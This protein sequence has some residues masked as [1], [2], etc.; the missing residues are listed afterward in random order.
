[1]NKMVFINKGLYGMLF[2]VRLVPNVDI[3]NTVQYNTIQYNSLHYTILHYTILCTLHYITLHC[4]TLHYITLHY[5]TLHYITLH[6]IT[7]HYITL[8][9]ITLHYIT[10]L[11]HCTALY[12]TTANTSVPAGRVKSE[13]KARVK[14]KA[15][16]KTQNIHPKC[17][18][19][20][21][22]CNKMAI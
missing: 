7:L 20:Q 5:I 19:R 3:Y 13:L 16:Q 17:L 15:S 6:Y 8:H 14:E 10:L 9:Y 22:G 18:S 1:M 11:L 12:H 4:I 2:A 21:G